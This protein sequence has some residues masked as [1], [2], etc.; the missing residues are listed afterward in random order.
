[1]CKC[2]FR[3][4]LRLDFMSER[5][6]ILIILI[7]LDATSFS[8]EAVVMFNV[9]GIRPLLSISRIVGDVK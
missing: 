4:N 9:S 3:L 1:M 6:R 8:Y 5:V 7:P 2:H